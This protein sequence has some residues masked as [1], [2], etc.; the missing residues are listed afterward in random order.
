MKAQPEKNVL[1]RECFYEDPLDEAAERFYTSTEWSEVHRLLSGN[2]RGKALDLGAGRGISSYALARDGWT[3]TALEP[4]PSDIVGAGAIRRLTAERQLSVSVVESWGEN[5]PFPAASFNLVYARQALHHALDLDHFCREA[6]RVLCPGGI[7]LATREHVISH[8]NDLSSFL[9]NHP[10][11]GLYGGENAYTLKR[12]ISAIE[13]SGIILKNV[14]ATYDSDINLFPGT[15]IGLNDQIFNKFK[16]RLPDRIIDS[17][18]IPLLNFIDTVP[19]RL[20]SF[21]GYKR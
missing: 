18:V 13:G 6:Y 3:V 8:E 2:Q 20:Y 16:I 12:Y 11:Q 10:L 9:D 21:V 5:L 7:F 1:V 17:M 19:G 15:K 4:D 14:L